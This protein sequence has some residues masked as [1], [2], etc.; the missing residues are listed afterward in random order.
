MLWVPKGLKYRNHCVP[1]RHDSH[2]V[3]PVSA[4]VS[5]TASSHCH[6]IIAIARRHDKGLLGRIYKSKESF[7]A[8]S[9]STLGNT[10]GLLHWPGNRRV[11]ND[12]EPVSSPITYK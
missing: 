6:S 5:E 9:C 12:D 11:L 10:I 8:R 1:E 4:H 7:W 2:E 3:E